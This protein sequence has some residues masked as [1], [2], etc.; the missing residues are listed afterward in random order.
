LAVGKRK[1]NQ[2]GNLLFMVPNDEGQG[3]LKHSET[4]CVDSVT[5]YP[6]TEIQTLFRGI[7]YF[8]LSSR[9]EGFGM[10]LIE[11]MACGLHVFHLIVYGPIKILF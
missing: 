1:K 8:V 6:A 7:F 4:M 10:V 2:I 9:Y 11:A 3:L 5:F